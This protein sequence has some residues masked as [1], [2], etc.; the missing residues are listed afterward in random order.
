[1][2]KPIQTSTPKAQISKSF[3]SDD[4][5]TL[6]PILKPNKQKARKS[7]SSSPKLPLSKTVLLPPSSHLPI[8]GAVLNKQPSSKSSMTLLTSVPAVPSFALAKPSTSLWPNPSS[9]LSAFNAA[10]ASNVST[11][12]KIPATTNSKV[13]LIN[14]AL[15]APVPDITSKISTSTVASNPVIL[16]QVS[17]KILMPSSNVVQAPLLQGSAAVVMKGPAACA[18]PPQ[19]FLVQQQTPDGQQKTFKLIRL[20]ANHP[21]ASAVPKPIQQTSIAPL[22]Q[23]QVILTSG[24]PG[25]VLMKD[26][27][28]LLSAVQKLQQ[29]PFPSAPVVKTSS[30]VNV[31]T[32]SPVNK[33]ASS[34]SVKNP[35]KPSLSSNEVKSA[36]LSCKLC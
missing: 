25:F 16:P 20:P 22:N 33:P 21:L 18:P 23:P 24:Q 17:N 14:Q 9:N 32:S 35:S 12:T 4:S 3:S 6:T 36:A 5:E 28:G 7:F 10:K 19:E 29:T 15:R 13:E 27:P 2:L 8:V 30:P 11:S 26:N 34:S 1:M 31:K